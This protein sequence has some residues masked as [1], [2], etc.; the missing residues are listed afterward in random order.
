MPDEPQNS[1]SSTS[2]S[3]SSSSGPDTPKK[4]RKSPGP[5][6]QAHLDELERA[7]DIIA[8]YRKPEHK[9]ILITKRDVLE[10]DVNTL[11]TTVNLAEN[12]ITGGHTATVAK[13]QLTA[14]ERLAKAALLAGIA[15]GQRGALRTFRSDQRA[16][17]E[18]YFIGENLDTN[19][20]RLKTIAIAILSRL[21]PG[22][23]NTPPLDV[24]KGVKA[25]DIQALADAL[26]AITAKDNAQGAAQVIA[27]E[28]RRTAEELIADIVAGR[29]DIQL[30]ADQEW[31]WTTREHDVIRAQFKLPLTRPMTE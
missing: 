27:S 17:L 5:F 25:P 1:S 8:A 12:K 21:Q 3:S 9:Q 19:L 28:E 18:D 15:T 22:A 6:N 10:A 13:E 4:P 29:L 2:S 20:P 24:L 26:A 11:E 23:N 30:A 14:E 31:P 16:R 7:R